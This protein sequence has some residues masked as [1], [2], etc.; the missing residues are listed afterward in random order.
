MAYSMDLP[1]IIEPLEPLSSGH[2]IVGRL[3]AVVDYFVPANNVE[4]SDEL[5]RSRILVGILFFY[6]AILLIGGSF[7]GLFTPPSTDYKTITYVM[8]FTP[9]LLFI[10]LLLS[11][12]S[13]AN[14]NLCANIHVSVAYTLVFSGVY[15]SGGPFISPANYVVHIPV[16]LAFCI[17]G[18]RAGFYWAG[19]VFGTMLTLILV[20]FAG[21]SYP[22]LMDQNSVNLHE[23]IDWTIAFS[24]TVAIVIVYEAMNL[25]R[26]SVV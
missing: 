15:I 3:G 4:D 12:R 2:S 5:F 23:C 11:Y 1:Q 17:I 6:I 14:H 26:K 24:A 19:I 21:Y 7:F 8:L 20:G 16:L 18:Q 9:A 10:G 22:Y 25:R 13:T